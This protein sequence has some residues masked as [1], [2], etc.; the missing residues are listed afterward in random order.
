VPFFVVLLSRR[1]H[2][3]RRTFPRRSAGYSF[4]VRSRLGSLVVEK[5]IALNNEMFIEREAEP[6][7]GNYYCHN[8]ELREG[9][10]DCSISGGV[11]IPTRMEWK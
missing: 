10:R 3:P 1:S 9:R 11:G 4:R 5:G 2:R 7:P 6:L 8:M